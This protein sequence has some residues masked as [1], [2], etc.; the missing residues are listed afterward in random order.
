MTTGTRKAGDT[1]ALARSIVAAV[2]MVAGVT[3]DEMR[4]RRSMRNSRLRGLCYAI[5][6][7]HCAL[8]A[9]VATVLGVRRSGFAR[10]ARTTL[11]LLETKTPEGDVWRALKAEAMARLP[12]PPVRV[13]EEVVLRP[14]RPSIVD[15]LRA[16]HKITQ[17]PPREVLAGG[18]W[19]DLLD[20]RFAIMRLA[21]R[22][23]YRPFEIARR[24]ERDKSTIISGLA[25]A[26]ALVAAGGQ[27]GQRI[28]ALAEAIDRR[29][30]GDKR[31]VVMINAH[32]RAVAEQI[33]A[34]SA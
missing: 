8:V 18:R 13:T 30:A 34:G 21:D 7:E 4:A 20:I 31:G 1:L 9:D 26:D 11:W 24:L 16:A 12:P 25:T 15:M 2:A 17:R 3:E 32:L 22:H 10:N 29:V 28:A 27:R 5:G 14:W 19:Q 33:R 6:L 23:G